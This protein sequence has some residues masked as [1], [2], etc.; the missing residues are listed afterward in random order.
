MRSRAS[1]FKWEY[2]LLSLRL[3]IRLL[4]R[5]L[6][7]SISPFIFPSIT[8]CRRQFLRKMWP[9][10]LAFRFLIS[11]RIFKAKS[12]T[13]NLCHSMVHRRGGNLHREATDIFFPCHNTWSHPMQLRCCF[14]W[15]LVANAVRKLFLGQTL[16]SP[17]LF[18][19]WASYIYTTFIYHVGNICAMFVVLTVV[20]VT[21]SFYV[22]G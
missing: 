7:T 13:C 14:T 20:C 5:L 9:I 16:V 8:C 17:I 15:R 11:C 18:G 21:C 12:L 4:P 6:F 2:P 19:H 3:S 1:S 10:Q 22:L